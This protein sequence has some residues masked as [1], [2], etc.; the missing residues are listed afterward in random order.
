MT[1]V[2]RK[3]D[4]KDGSTTV[5]PSTAVVGLICLFFWGLAVVTDQHWGDCSSTNSN[6][7]R[8]EYSSCSN[9][10]NNSTNSNKEKIVIMQ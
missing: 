6:H 9:N 7:N 5:Q 3:G 2:S 10:G 8:S 4:D 1:W